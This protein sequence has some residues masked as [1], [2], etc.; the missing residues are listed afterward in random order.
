LHTIGRVAEETGRRVA[1]AGRS[2][3]R[4]LK[5]AKAT[6]YLTDFPE[7]V[8]YDEAMRLPRRELLVIATGGQ[9]EPRAALGRIA[10]GQ[11]EIKF[12]EMDTVIFSSR[13]IPGNENAVGRVM[14]Q[15]AELGVRTVTER[16][17]HVHVSGHPGRPELIQMYDWIRPKLLIPVHGER[18]HMLEQARLGLDNGIPA[19]LVQ[20]NGDLIRL[21]PG[22]PK[23]ISAERVGRLVLDGD[24]ILPA[25]G[26]TIN[27]RR[28]IAYQGVVAVSLVV[29]KSG[30]LAADPV[31]RTLGVPVEEDR[32]DFLRDAAVTAAKAVQPSQDEEKLRE[33]VRLAVRRCAT[34]WTGK[35]PNVEVLVTRL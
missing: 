12:G 27:E 11:H 13:Q 10:A 24:V 8:R 9:G 5:V 14:N 26:S 20:E 29:A 2:I 25:D 32:D 35:K 4:Y 16:Q 18:R 22:E 21:A 7:T 3:E 23:K 28:R 15:L 33:N 31:V 17:A 19:A 30:R 6:G 34:L 1:I